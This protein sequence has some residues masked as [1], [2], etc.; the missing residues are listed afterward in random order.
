[1]SRFDVK[2]FGEAS[3]FLRKSDLEL[4]AMQTTAFDGRP[5]KETSKELNLKALHLR[6]SLLK[7]EKSIVL[8]LGLF[9]LVTKLCLM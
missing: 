7:K 6:N 5:F 2:E 3:P 1:M 4:L 8:R 9:V